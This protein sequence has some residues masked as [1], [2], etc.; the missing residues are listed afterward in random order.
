MNDLLK[1][2]YDHFYEPLPLERQK[3][4]VETCHRKLIE[5]LD[6]PTRKIVLQL[7]DTE[8]QIADALST[9]SFIAGFRLAW[10]LL[11]ELNIYEKMRPL[12]ITRPVGVDA[13]A[14]SEE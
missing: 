12:P 9:D 7:I 6:K 8:D 10:R 14:M 2:L 13:F 4:E 1:A 11:H 3:E 5:M